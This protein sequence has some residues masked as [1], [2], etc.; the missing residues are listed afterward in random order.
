MTS[1]HHFHSNNGSMRQRPGGA[2]LILQQSWKLWDHF[3]PSRAEGRFRV[4]R[5]RLLCFTERVDYIKCSHANNQ[6]ENLHR[7]YNSESYAKQ[8][9]SVRGTQWL[10]SQCV[11]STVLTVSSLCSCCV[12]KFDTQRESHFQKA[13]SGFLSSIYTYI[14]W[15]LGVY[16]AGYQP[17]RWCFWYYSG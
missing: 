7:G 11:T 9:L 15:S 4:K 13:F 2:S 14:L 8:Q 6:R 17:G 16:V 3:Q 10:W 12:N 5:R 1:V